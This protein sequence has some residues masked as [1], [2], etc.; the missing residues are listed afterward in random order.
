MDRELDNFGASLGEALADVFVQEQQSRQDVPCTVDTPKIVALGLINRDASLLTVDARKAQSGY[1]VIGPAVPGTSLTELA[2]TAQVV[3]WQYHPIRA[4]HQGHIVRHPCVIPHG[5]VMLKCVDCG[6]SAKLWAYEAY[7][8]KERKGDFKCP[9]CGGRQLKKNLVPALTASELPS[10]PVTTEDGGVID[11]IL[12]AWSAGP[13][14]NNALA[15]P[16][17]WCGYNL[18]HTP[19]LWKP[20]DERAA[21]IE[22]KFAAVRKGS[23]YPY[24]LA[25]KTG[26]RNVQAWLLELPTGL[27]VGWASERSLI[28]P[29]ESPIKLNFLGRPNGAA[30]V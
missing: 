1:T 27:S 14:A 18:G 29:P 6:E 17:I 22:R 26:F 8:L 11:A 20:Q 28:M 24:E 21:L 5:R 15:L 30:G 9:K 19:G 12:D 23:I 2:A 25:E 4:D 3:R 16:R 10:E 13:S 7:D